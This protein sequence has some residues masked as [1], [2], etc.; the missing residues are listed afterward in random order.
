MLI[1]HWQQMPQSL[2]RCLLQASNQPALVGLAE[3]APAVAA[4]THLLVSLLQQV[5]QAPGYSTQK[6]HSAAAAGGAS[7][8]LPWC[9]EMPYCNSFYRQ[10][11]MG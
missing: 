5:L 7:G 1:S 2:Q 11:A 8:W 9:A 3:L 4:V 10:L 6:P